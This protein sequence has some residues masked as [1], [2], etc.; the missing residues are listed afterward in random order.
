M[1]RFVVV[2]VRMRP[3]SAKRD[4]ENGDERVSSSASLLSLL[5]SNKKGWEEVL[6]ICIF[7]KWP[8]PSMGHA[9]RESW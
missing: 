6:I 4:L 7:Q 1:L 2:V 5:Q 9:C 8:I 3:S